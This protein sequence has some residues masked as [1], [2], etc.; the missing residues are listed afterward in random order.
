MERI[1]FFRGSRRAAGRCMIAAIG[2]TTARRLEALG[3]PPD[4]VP[5]RPDLGEM[6]AGLVDV[7]RA[8]HEA[9]SPAKGNG[10]E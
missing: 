4:C 1:I 9:E 5:E 8:R 7:A 2:R 10:E 6:V 3:L